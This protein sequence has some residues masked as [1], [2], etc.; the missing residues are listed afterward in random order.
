MIF[1]KKI[2]EREIREIFQYWLERRPPNGVPDRGSIDP[3]TIPYK[4]LPSLFLYEAEPEGRF[5][6]KLIGTD[7]TR[8]LGRDETGQY[9]DEMLDPAVAKER[10]KLFK[11]AVASGR[12]VYYRY[13]AVTAR[14]DRRLFARILLPVASAGD[15][16]DHVFGMV[17]YGSVEHRSERLQPLATEN[18]LS[19]VVTA[20][21]EDMTIPMADS[22]AK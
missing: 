10:S 4:Y 1:T 12:P 20:T 3:R 18:G 21:D 6:C 19:E 17:R 8:I 14:G 13:R 22:A 9:L 16:A 2:H 11:Q 15:K 5:R 7:I